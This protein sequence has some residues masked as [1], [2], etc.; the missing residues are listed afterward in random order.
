MLL[1]CVCKA[2]EL[3][4]EPILGLQDKTIVFPGYVCLMASKN[5]ILDCGFPVSAHNKKKTRQTST[6]KQED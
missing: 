1:I 5:T 3:D 4:F 2:Q 6:N